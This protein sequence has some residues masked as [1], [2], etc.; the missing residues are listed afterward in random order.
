MKLITITTLTGDENP[1]CHKSPDQKNIDHLGLQ[2][3]CNQFLHELFRKTLPDSLILTHFRCDF[4]C[5]EGVN[6]FKLLSLTMKKDCWSEERP[7]ETTFVNEI[8]FIKPTKRS[9]TYI[10]NSVQFLVILQHFS[11]PLW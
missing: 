9:T 8:V 1:L 3:H 6:S 7:V 10:S 4:C 2:S 5:N 11:K